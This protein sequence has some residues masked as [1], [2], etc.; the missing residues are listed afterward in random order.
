MKRIEFPKGTSIEDAV[1]E[2]LAAKSRGEKVCGVINGHT[3]YSD[4]VTM[5]SA[6]LE[7]TGY[8]KEEYDKILLEVSENYRKD[9]AERILMNEDYRSANYHGNE[10]ENKNHIKMEKVV[11]A[12]KF[13]AE[14]QHLTTEEY[15]LGLLN[16]GI[17]FTFDDIDEQFPEK[18]GLLYGIKHGELS[19]GAE[20]VVMAN[21]GKYGRSHVEN[22]FLAY[23][24]ESSIYNFI[25]VVTGDK[26]YTK[27]NLE[28]LKKQVKK[29]KITMPVVVEALKFIVQNQDMSQEELNTLLTEL[30]VDFNFDDLTRQ[31]PGS[32]PQFKGMASG[33]LAAGASV[34]LNVM[35]GGVS[36][37]YTNMA[38]LSKDNE[39]S[40][41]N[42]IRVVTGDENYTMENLFN[43]KKTGSRK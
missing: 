18:S 7:I 9:E 32:V 19:S 13:I 30:G 43:N 14:N 3:F 35:A 25:R 23:D 28:K 15:E 41:Y 12:L 26:N 5:D 27:E 37:D 17:D 4:S 38:F 6:F 22:K 33:H 20:I 36:R 16:I 40:V 31:F 42:F 8:T 39:T 11:K 10:S 24:D 2:L 29:S 1:N 34:V 21:S